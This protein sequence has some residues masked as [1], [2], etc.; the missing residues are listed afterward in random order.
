MN[1]L[2]QDF[3]TRLISAWKWSRESPKWGCKVVWIGQCTL[4]PLIYPNKHSLSLPPWIQGLSSKPFAAPPCPQSLTRPSLLCV[5][6]NHW[7]HRI[8]THTHSRT[9]THTQS[10]ILH[11]RFRI[12]KQNVREG[13]AEASGKAESNSSLLNAFLLRSIRSRRERFTFITGI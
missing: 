12:R 4:T 7:Q 6:S 9:H 8:R 10:G 5:H 1:H 13:S 11:T 3:E 2:F